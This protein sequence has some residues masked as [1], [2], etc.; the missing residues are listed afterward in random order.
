ML[1]NAPFI[2][3]T[4]PHRPGKARKATAEGGSDP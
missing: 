3:A 2:V 4:S 1:S